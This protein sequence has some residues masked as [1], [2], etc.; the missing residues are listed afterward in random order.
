MDVYFE[1]NSFN[2]VIG[3]DK[4]SYKAVGVLEKNSWNKFI[5]IYHNHFK[6]QDTKQFTPS[7]LHLWL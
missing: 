6:N 5:N 3:S 2:S 7:L 1:T 4:S